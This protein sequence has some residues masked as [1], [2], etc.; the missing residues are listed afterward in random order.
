MDALVFMTI[1]GL[2]VAGIFAYS[3]PA[4]K[5][6]D[7]KEVHDMFFSVELRTSDLFDDPD[8]Q[9]IRMCDLVAVCILT[10]DEDILDRIEKILH[11]LAPPFS[12]CIFVFEYGGHT[13]VIG[14]TG[15]KLRSQYS[16]SVAVSDGNIMRTTL[17]IY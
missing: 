13:L 7:A 8:T 4:E 10:G 16:S 1:I 15:E 14:E 12:G 17:T 11:S 9:I 6:T 3:A 5:N 2:L